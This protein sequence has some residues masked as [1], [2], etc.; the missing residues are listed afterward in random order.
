MGHFCGLD[1]GTSNSALSASIDGEVQL[2]SLD[3]GLKPRKIIPS[4]IFFNAEEKTRVFGARAIDEYV[5][6]YVGR[7]MRSLKSVLGSSLMGGKTEVGASAV[8]YGDIIGMFVRFM[9]E[10]GEQ[11]LGDSLEHVV[12]GRPVFF[13]DEDP[14]ADRKA[15]SE[16]EA[17]VKAVGF[18]SVSFEFEPIAAALDYERQLDTESTVLTVDI[19]G[20]TSDFSIMSLSPKKVMTDDRAQDILAHAGVHIGGTDFD[21]ALS[22]HSV[23]PAFGLGSKLESGLDIPVMQFH[24]L[25]TW[26]EINNLYT[27]E[28]TDMIKSLKLRSTSPELIARFI[29]LLDQRRGHYLAQL[30]EN[31]KVAL[32]ESDATHVNLD[33]VEKGLDI[34]VSQQDLKEATESRVE[35]IM[36]TAEET[37]K[38]AGLSKDKIDRIVLTGGSTAM[39]GFEA[40]VQACFPETPIVKGDRFASIG[41]GLGLVAQ[42]RYR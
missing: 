1:F 36:N 41:Q 38:M 28:A 37:V 33:F 15:Q 30:V 34:P 29:K 24:E 16:L 26:H 39:P 12:V 10:Q 13:V 7:L 5:D 25:A 14:E 9:K 19:G 18:K 8:N 35:R 22:L 23:L 11:Q 20:G 3:D 31:A 32:S 40:S 27:R 2:V 42:N 6:G 21:R 17:I 4:A